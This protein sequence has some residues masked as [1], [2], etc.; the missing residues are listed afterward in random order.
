[1]TTLF[2]RDTHRRSAPANV[3]LK[4]SFAMSDRMDETRGHTRWEDASKA[5]GAPNLSDDVDA[6]EDETKLNNSGR[7]CAT[8]SNME[9]R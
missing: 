6:Y 8:V 7:S 5:L 3:A 9:S 4:Q 1:M 2:P